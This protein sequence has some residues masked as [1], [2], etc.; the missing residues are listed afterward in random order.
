MAWY[1]DKISALS[2]EGVEL[3]DSDINIMKKYTNEVQFNKAA[4][5]AFRRASGS[6][7]LPGGDDN[8]K[9]Q[10]TLEILK[11]LGSD[12]EKYDIKIPDGYPEGIRPSDEDIERFKTD[13]AEAGLLPFQVKR[14]FETALASQKV[15]YEKN[16][17]E[18]ATEVKEKGESLETF[19]KTLVEGQGDKYD[20][21]VQSV[22]RVME[23]YEFGQDL[24]DDKKQPTDKFF[25]LGDSLKSWE[26]IAADNGETDFVPGSSGGKSDSEVDY[27]KVFPNSDFLPNG[28][29]AN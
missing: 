5:H 15:A 20:T 12:K 14:N 18:L 11:Q 8:E 7:T 28:Q 22:R 23:K 2:A 6:I 19:K 1:D 27:S 9:Q 25:E 29:L 26:K 13:S 24:F 17:S 4:F 16:Q 10:R 21:Y 3:S